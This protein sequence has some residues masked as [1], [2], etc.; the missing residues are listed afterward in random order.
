[1]TSSV[2][3][4]QVKVPGLDTANRSFQLHGQGEDGKT[5]LEEKLSR[6]ELTTFMANIPSCV[7]GMEACVGFSSL[8]SYFH[9]YGT[10]GASDGPAV[11]QVVR[12]IELER[13][14]R[15]RGDPP[16]LH[17]ARQPSGSMPLNALRAGKEH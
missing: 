13:R 2:K 12:K 7:V 10:Y 3:K 6:K 1:M 4:G 17:S 11:R 9:R 14:S 5:V 16:C 15:S 8:V